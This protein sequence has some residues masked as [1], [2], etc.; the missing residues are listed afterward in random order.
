MPNSGTQKEGGNTDGRD[1]EKRL[2][3]EAKSVDRGLGKGRTRSSGFRQRG[4][5][6]EEERAGN[7]HE[8]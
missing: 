2:L 6:R 8:E 1:A 7:V 4:V 3:L 5:P